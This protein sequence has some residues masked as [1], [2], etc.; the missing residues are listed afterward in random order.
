MKYS[1][2]LISLLALFFASFTPGMIRSM[3]TPDAKTQQVSSNQDKAYL[4]NKLTPIRGAQVGIIG[5]ITDKSGNKKEVIVSQEG[6]STEL[7]PISSIASIEIARYFKHPIFGQYSPTTLLWEKFLRKVD[8]ITQ[9]LL[10]NY[11]ENND[12][13]IE[14]Y[15]K[16]PN[17]Y[18]WEWQYKFMVGKV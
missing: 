11:K 14:V 7:G 12:V 9:D 8:N 10:T 13:Y 17:S 2:K 18:S 16:D 6:E 5:Y 15:W 4:I 3:E 1:G